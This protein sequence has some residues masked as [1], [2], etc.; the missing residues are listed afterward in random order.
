MQIDNQASKQRESSTP[1]VLAIELLALE[2][3]RCTRC[4]GTRRNIEKAIEIIGPALEVMGVQVNVE[5]TIIESD[6]Q[7]RRHRFATSP[8]VRI[9]GKDIALEM[10]ESECD[11]CTDLRGGDDATSCRVWLY[12]GQEYTEAPVGL[13][14]ES[15]LRETL[16]PNSESTNQE[17]DDGGQVL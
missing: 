14:V 8:T 5:T 17:E 13:I 16:A 7:A 2:L 15:I 4:V 9:N 12:R 10:A 6:A 1:R 11:V 3:N